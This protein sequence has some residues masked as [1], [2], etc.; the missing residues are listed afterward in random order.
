VFGLILG[1]LRFTPAKGDAI[2]LKHN[3]H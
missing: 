3:V 2:A 1:E